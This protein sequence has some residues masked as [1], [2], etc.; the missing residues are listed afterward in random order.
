MELLSDGASASAAALAVN[1]AILGVTSAV[2][3]V[4]VDQCNNSSLSGPARLPDPEGRY[5]GGP[6]PRLSLLVSVPPRKAEIQNLTSKR[7]F[8][9]ISWKSNGFWGHIKVIFNKYII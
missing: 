4:R 3:L 5:A 7:K 2:F 1:S 8:Y 6:R 9:R